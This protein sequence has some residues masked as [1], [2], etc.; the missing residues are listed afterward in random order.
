MSLDPRTPVL[1]GVGAVVERPEDPADAMEPLALMEAALRRAADDAGAPALLAQADAIWAP[2]GFWSYSDPGRLLAERFGAP[3]PRTIIAEVGVLQ[4]T[5]LGRAASAIAAGESDV[6]MI[7]GAEARDRA[8]R[9]QRQGL[10]VPLTEQTEPTPDEV[11]VPHAEIMGALEI[12]LG[13]VTPTIQYAMIDNALRFAEGQTI[14]AHR[15]A[16]GEL[17]GDFN[18]AAVSNPYA[19]NRTPMSHEA[20]VTPGEG[21]RMLA[22]PYTKSLVSQWNVNQAGALLLCSLERAQALSLDASRFI[23]PLAVIDSEH[24]VTLSERRDPARSPGFALAGRRALEAVGRTPEEIELWE[25]YSCFPAA[26]RAQ[27][28]EIGIPEDRRLTQ[29]GGMTFGGGPLNNFVIQSWVSMVERMRETPGAHGVVTAVSGLL[30]K[31]GVSV[32]GPEP[33]RAFLHDAVTKETEQAWETVAVDRD[34]TGPGRIATYTVSHDR[35]AAH[36]VALIADLDDGRRT[37][38]VVDDPEWMA[39]GEREELCGRAI[40]VEPEG[41]VRWA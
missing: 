37:L 27:R 29:T 26:V 3:S 10:D 19:W 24:M 8:T 31:Q 20:I 39:L 18:A 12:E 25:C 7:V 40:V 11:L 41:G 9:L 30:T 33:S 16:L 34:A 22:F 36:G 2:R 1:V 14:E 32:L 6:A 5:I 17:W 23:Y 4:T 28:R 13:L 38:R 15:A 35:N 21:N